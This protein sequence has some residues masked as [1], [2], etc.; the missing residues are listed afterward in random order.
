MK[1][2]GE[3]GDAEIRWWGVVLFD[4]AVEDIGGALDFRFYDC[5]QIEGGGFLGFDFGEDASDEAH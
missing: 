4:A 2:K 5:G 3:F 1:I